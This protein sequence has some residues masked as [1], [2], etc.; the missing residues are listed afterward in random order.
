MG[1]LIY[2]FLRRLGLGEISPAGRR[3]V[4]AGSVRISVRAEFYE[5]VVNFCFDP[6]ARSTAL[7]RPG[8][9]RGSWMLYPRFGS[10]TSRC[11]FSVCWF[12]CRLVNIIRK[13]VV[14]PKRG[15]RAAKTGVRV[16]SGGRLLCLCENG[17]LCFDSQSIAHR[18]LTA[19]RLH[20]GLLLDLF[21]GAYCA[22]TSPSLGFEAKP[23]CFTVF[24]GTRTV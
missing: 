15:E 1:C 7:E 13:P 8:A 9:S 2:V 18:L 11:I 10:W 17:L 4:A 16:G 24:P 14:K 5:D 21:R 22:L 3:T 23:V 19:S 12:Y 6:V 20:L